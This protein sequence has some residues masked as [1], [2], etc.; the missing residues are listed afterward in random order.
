M[1]VTPQRRFSPSSRVVRAP[2]LNATV[3]V[4]AHVTPVREMLALELAPEL[5]QRWLVRGRPAPELA[6]ALEGVRARL[7]DEL[8]IAVPAP[9]VRPSQALVARQYRWLWRELPQPAELAPDPLEAPQLA[10]TLAPLVRRHAADCLGLDQLLDARVAIAAVQAIRR[11]A[12]LGAIALVVGVEEIE[13]DAPDLRLPHLAVHVVLAELDRHL[14]RLAR[15]HDRRD[16]QVAEIVVVVDRV[17]R[18]FRIDRLLE[19]PLPV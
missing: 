3:R 18:A 15:M 9:D 6:A 2:N 19:I 7:S 12:I 16:R 1:E 10:A 4:E 8:G 5:A 13:R 14:E 11:G 17:L